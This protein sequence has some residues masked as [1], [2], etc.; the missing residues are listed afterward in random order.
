[1]APQ[2]SVDPQLIKTVR[3]RTGAGL[4]ECKEAL[5]QAGGDLEK[6]IE[7]LRRKGGAAAE[8]KAGRTTSEGVIA[9][10]IHAG[11]RLGVL[12]EINCETDFVARTP[13]FQE[14]AHNLALQIAGAEPAARWTS[15][16]EVPAEV[17]ERERSIYRDQA[18]MTGKPERV[19]EQIVSGRVEKFLSETCLLEQPYLREPEI[20]VRELLNRVIAKVGENISVRRFCRYRL[21]EPLN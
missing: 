2:M 14:L 6:A 12:L 10:Y 11:G 8:K 4:L 17:L 13:D 9:S 21:G 16:E 19:V 20:K 18:K 1:M 15:R 7:I 3:E 5:S